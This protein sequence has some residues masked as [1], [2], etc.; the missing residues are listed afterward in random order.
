MNA[1]TPLRGLVCRMLPILLAAGGPAAAQLTSTDLEYLAQQAESEGWTFEVGANPAT[2]RSLE[3]LCDLRMPANWQAEARV[4]PL[5]PPDSG[6]AA[7]PAA[8]DWRAQNGCTPIR[9]QAACG[10]PYAHPTAISGWYYV[11]PYATVPST[12]AIKQAILSYGPVSVAVYVNSAFQAYRGGVFNGCGTGT[13]NHAV[14]LVGWDDADQAWILRN[15]WGPYWGESGYMRIRYG[16][17]QVGYAACYVDYRQTSVI[18]GTTLTS[19]ASGSTLTSSSA[20]FQWDSHPQGTEY[21]LNLGDKAGSANLY[22]ASQGTGTSVTVDNLPVN[23]A[24][25][26]AKLFTSINGKWYGKAA[27]YKAANLP[28]QSAR[29]TSPAPGGTLTDTTTTFQWSAGARVSEY[30]LWIG[31]TPGGYNL[32]RQ[33]LG[34]GTSATVTNLPAGGRKLYVRLLSR[35][36]TVT[37]RMDYT[38]TSLTSPPAAAAISDPPDGALLDSSTAALSWTE[39]VGVEEYALQVGTAA[40]GKN[41]YNRSLGRS[42]SATLSGLP[43]SGNALYVRLW[44]R[45]GSTWYY[46]DTRYTT[47]NL[48]TG[49]AEMTS[50]V[51]SS[52][53]E[54]HTVTF[55]WAEGVG[56]TGYQLGIGNTLGK[57][58]LYNQLMGLNLSA[59][60]SGLPTDGRPLYVRLWTQIGGKWQ[61]KDYVY[62]AVSLA[63]SAAQMTS[64]AAGST[65]TSSLVTFEWSAGTGVAEYWLTVGTRL[66]G[67]DLYNRSQGLRQSVTVANLP[68]NSSLVYVR[69]SSRINGT[70]QKLDYTYRAAA[71]G[72]ARP[73][74]AG[75]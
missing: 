69:L 26:Y 42:R 66:G 57:Y 11:D 13:I 25:L 43:T 53:L 17:S 72:T 49:P 60:V 31:T 9:N 8:W 46:N 6:L 61:Q 41:V 7:P 52:T 3:A 45:S 4:N 62:T 10:G 34:L 59:T 1:F 18:E 24:T 64:P 15:S 47:P 32:Y 54:S 16:C 44:S 14:V 40:G 39:G 58:T 33:S 55:T 2:H 35:I 73:V 37:N 29:M 20:T 19:P 23:G 65:L 50:P 63:N 68:V 56:A 74:P 27:T 5:G 21:W 70:W 48:A 28:A 22:S 71:P 38:Y 67:T 30:T 36:G 51:S 12:A 75:G